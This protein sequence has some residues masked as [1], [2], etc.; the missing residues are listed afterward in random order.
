MSLDM[1][2]K[3]TNID[4]NVT[5]NLVPMAQ[6]CG[7]YEPMWNAYGPA[8][9]LILPLTA[10]VVNLACN[11]ARFE[12]FNPENGWGDYD[13]LLQVATKWLQAVTDNQNDGFAE[14]HG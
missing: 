2:I 5:H 14:S 6:A 8:V 3:G 4:L 13:N 11:R 12:R 1:M 10:G 9:D 7:L